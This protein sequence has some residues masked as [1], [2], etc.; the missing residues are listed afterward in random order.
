MCGRREVEAPLLARYRRHY[1]TGLVLRSTPYDGVP[2]L[3]A[4]LSAQGAPMAICSNKPERQAED[5]LV[6]LGLRR[7]FALVVGA[8]TCSERKPHPAPLRHAVARLGGPPSEALFIGDS[9]VDAACAQ[10]A[11]LAHLWFGRGYGA[12]PAVGALRF[13]SYRELLTR[14][15]ATAA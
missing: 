6:A 12:P 4:Q 15:C 10:A 14:V 3:L 7:H 1:A 2:D 5:L 13:D 8:D 9:A 11:G